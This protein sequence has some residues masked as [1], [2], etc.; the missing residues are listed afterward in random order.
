MLQAISIKDEMFE[1]YEYLMDTSQ[2]SLQTQWRL[3][4]FL[5]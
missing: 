3:I 1:K 2:I 4:W 5:N